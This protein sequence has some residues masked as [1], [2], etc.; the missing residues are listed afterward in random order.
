MANEWR[1]AVA[2]AD[3]PEGK[4]IRVTADGSD[5]LLFR[6][7]ITSWRYPT[8]APIRAPHSTGVW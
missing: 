8:D 5:V 3:L 2:L 7:G 4:P 6:T 1:L